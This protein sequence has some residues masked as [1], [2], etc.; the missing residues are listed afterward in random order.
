MLYKANIEHHWLSKLSLN[1]KQTVSSLQSQREYHKAC[2]FGVIY[3]VE[4]FCFAFKSRNT[5]QKPRAA[6]L[7]TMYRSLLFVAIA[8]IDKD[9]SLLWRAA[10]MN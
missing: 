3:K 2:V 4:M 9:L 10:N 6:I 8:E 1:M 7:A 5:K